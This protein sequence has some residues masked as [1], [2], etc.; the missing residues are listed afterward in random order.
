MVRTV[1]FTLFALFAFNSFSQGFTYEQFQK[2]QQVVERE[3]SQWAKSQPYVILISIDGFRYDYAKKHNAE[4]ILRLAKTGVSAEHMLSSFPTKTFPN[5]YT[6]VTG[7]YP[8]THGIVSNEFYSKSKDEWYTLKKKKSILDSSWYG[9]VPLWVLAEKNKMCSASLYWV[10]S[11]AAIGGLLPTYYYAYDGAV[12]NQY[13]IKQMIDWLKLPEAIRPHLVLGYFS[14]VDDVGHRYG[15]D[16]AE[17][18]KAV[19]EIDSLIGKLI[20]EVGGLGLPVHLVLVSDHGMSAINRGLV[21]PEIVDLG[22]SE[23]SY[24]FPPMIYQKD[25]LEIDRIYEVLLKTNLIEIYKKENIPGYLNFNN[26]DRV[27]DLVLLTEAPTVII[28]APKRISGG[29]HGFS[30]FSN[31]EMG[32]IFYASGPAL[33]KDLVVPP[34]ENIHVYPFIAKILSLPVPAEV[35]GSIDVLNPAFK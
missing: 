18:K 6:L 25:T 10:G 20:A 9:G 29:T 21:L 14:L 30:P 34:F 15:P 26:D 31:K 28:P 3:N 27:G 1:F 32:A 4:N 5:H 7:L 8:G 11:E 16:H 19:L 13:R 12:P 22:D 33:K 2:R 17:T 24:S 35:E 23:V